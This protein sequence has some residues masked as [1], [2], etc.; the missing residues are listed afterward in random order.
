MASSNLE[1]LNELIQKIKAG[2]GTAES[3]L[4]ALNMLCIIAGGTGTAKSNLEAL[5]ELLTVFTPGGETQEKSVTIRA[6]GTTEITPDEG[7]TLSKAVV[8]TDVPTKPEQTKSVTITANGITGVRPDPGHVL[9]GVT[10]DTVVPVKME[11]TKKVIITENGTTEIT[12]D[13]GYVLSSASVS[14]SVSGGS[15]GNA[16]VSKIDTG[17]GIVRNITKVNLNNVTL[18]QYGNCNALFSGFESLQEIIWGNFLSN[19]TK[20]VDFSNGFNGCKK[21]TS[22]DF[23][24][25][26]NLTIINIGGMF[27]GSTA[28]ESINWGSVKIQSTG[29]ANIFYDCGALRDVDLSLIDTSVLTST[30]YGSEYAFSKCYALTNVVFENNCFSN[31]SM[32]K[33]S[34][35]DCP[36]SHDCAVNIFN[37]LATRTNSPTLTLSATTKDYLTADEIA[38]ATGKGWVI[39]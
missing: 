2:E 7:Y 21:L 16:T 34:F 25:A 22:V 31:S 23:S 4:E 35:V 29:W 10:I 20:D 14:V 33:L 32:T 11:Q 12:P 26:G 30:F 38:I 15:E 8:V 37:K 19:I 9:T 36:L 28:L 3:N 39:S 18:S 5:N 13:E 6:N 24:S 17:G 27:H 1:A